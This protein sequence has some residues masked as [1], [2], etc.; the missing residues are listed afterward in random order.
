MPATPAHQLRGSAPTRCRGTLAWTPRR[1]RASSGPLECLA[2]SQP[3]MSFFEPRPQWRTKQENS[4]ER[5][6]VETVSRSRGSSA[7]CRRGFPTAHRPAP[8]NF[9]EGGVEL[10]LRGESVWLALIGWL[11][12]AACGLSARLKAIGACQK[13]ITA[14]GGGGWVV[15]TIDS[16]GRS[17]TWHMPAAQ[18]ANRSL[19]IHP[20]E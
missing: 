3:D 15:S 10:W 7:W 1:T 14:G 5:Q 6:N 20:R 18:P 8:P 2:H 12:R 17:C 13:K 11:V 19:T 4:S 16:S 9:G